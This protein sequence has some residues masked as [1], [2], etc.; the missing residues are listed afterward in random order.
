LYLVKCGV[1][2]DVAF[3]LDEVERMAYVVVFG[4]FSGLRYN[5]KLLRWEA[6]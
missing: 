1:P 5:W 6:I 4:E 2:Y 3:S